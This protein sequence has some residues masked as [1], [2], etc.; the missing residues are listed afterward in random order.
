LARLT[1]ERNLTFKWDAVEGASAYIFS[2]FREED[3]P[4]LLYTGTPDPSASFVLTDLSLLAGTESTNFI[5]QAEAVARNANGVIE[6]RGTIE[7]HRFRV[8]IRRSGTIQAGSSG[9]I[10]GQ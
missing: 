2:L 5:W 4:R 9:E 6:Q 3:P 8:E 10:Y 7:Q 1:Q